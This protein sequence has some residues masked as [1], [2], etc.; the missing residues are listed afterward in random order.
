M[1]VL[2]SEDDLVSPPAP[3]S[4]IVH[5]LLHCSAPM[6]SSPSRIKTC[7]VPLF[8]T[9]CRVR[10]RPREVLLYE[11]FLPGERLRGGRS[12]S[13]RADPSSGNMCHRPWE[14]GSLI[15]RPASVC[16]RYLVHRLSLSVSRPQELHSVRGVV[17]GT[18]CGSHRHRLHAMRTRRTMYSWS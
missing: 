8:T 2:R 7:E 12:C 6:S 16:A 11:T 18:F 5:P 3:R 14:T 15:S 13:A 9:R 1:Y 10:C 17:D 4:G